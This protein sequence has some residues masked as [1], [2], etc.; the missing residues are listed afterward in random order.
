MHG[1]LLETGAGWCHIPTVAGRVPWNR[2]GRDGRQEMEIGGDGYR[3]PPYMIHPGDEVGMSQGQGYLSASEGLAEPLNTLIGD[4]HDQ[5]CLLRTLALK[6]SLD[7]D[8]QLPSLQPR[9]VKS[10]KILL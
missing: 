3:R 5:S 8:T 2:D 7:P 10:V 1:V 4:S 6:P 9:L